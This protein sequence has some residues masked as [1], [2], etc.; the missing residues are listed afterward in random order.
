MGN[1]GFKSKHSQVE[2]LSF[3]SCFQPPVPPRGNKCYCLFAEY[4]PL[5]HSEAGLERRCLKTGFASLG[6][7]PPEGW[8][9]QERGLLGCFESA[10]SKHRPRAFNTCAVIT[11]LRV[12]LASWTVSLLEAAWASPSS[13]PSITSGNGS[14]WPIEQACRSLERRCALGAP[15]GNPTWYPSHFQPRTPHPIRP[16]EGLQ[17]S[18]IHQASAHEAAFSQPSTSLPSTGVPTRSMTVQ[19]HQGHPGCCLSHLTHLSMMLSEPSRCLLRWD[20]SPGAEHRKGLIMF[21]MDLKAKHR[22]LGTKVRK[23]VM[24]QNLTSGSCGKRV[25][26]KVR[27]PAKRRREK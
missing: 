1:R 21:K 5:P 6:L 19:G 20:H 25:T 7:L 8:E 17:L 26:D 15:L 14:K 27:A 23:I 22:A 4:Q 12:F 16:S 2:V 9:S 24:A 18:L 13:D 10:F 3:H 11:Y